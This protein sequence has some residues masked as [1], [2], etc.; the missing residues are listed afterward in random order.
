MNLQGEAVGDAF[1]Q[2][3]DSGVRRREDRGVLQQFGHE[4]REVG[5][6]RAADG[7]P[8]KTADLD[9]FVVLDLGDGGAHDVHQLHGLAPLPGGRGAGEDHQA[10][11]VPAHA[12]GQVVEAEQVGEFLGVLGPA[13]HGV[14]ESELLV[15]QDLAAAR[16]VDEDL[17]DAGAQFSL[18]DGGFDGGALQGVEGLADLAHLVLVVFEA[19]DLGLDV[20]LLARGEAAHDTGQ[21]YSGRFVGLQTQLP[22]IPDEGAADAHGQEEG[23]Q[24]RDQAECTG[25]DGLGDDADG[26]GVDAVLVAVVGLVV[27]GAELVEHIA[28]G[29]VPALGG[30]AAGT[31]GPGGDGGFLGHAQGSGG[32]VLPE[33][34]V[35]VAF[36]HGQQRQ[37]DVVHQGA[38]GHEVGD[39]PLFG[40]RDPADDQGGAEEGVLA[41]EQFAGAGEVDQRAVLLVQFGVVDHVQVGEEDVAGVDQPVV[42][43]EGLGA[44]DGA[45]LNAAAQRLDAVEG[46]QDGGQ[47]LVGVRSHRVAH[48]GVPGVLADA[49][50]GLV[51]GVPA[52]PERGEAVGRAG[53]GE[54]DEGLA[55]FLLEDSD[56]VLDGVADLLHHGR[57]VEEVAGLTSR[58]HRGE[59]PDRGQG[60][61]RHEKERHDLPADGFP[62]KAHGLPQLGPP[63][64]RGTHVRQQTARAYYRPT[65]NSKAGPEPEVPR[66]PRVMASCP[67]IAGVVC[68]K[69][70]VA[71]GSNPPTAPGWLA[72]NFRFPGIFV[73]SCSSSLWE[74]GAESAT[75][76]AS[77]TWAA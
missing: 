9:A 68:L 47:P 30:D 3:L 51:G 57:H 43:V 40:V 22:Q 53:V 10:F 6:G 23:E 19:R 8:R 72:E 38:L 21:P 13:L 70:V 62:A 5:D 48:V 17:G 20:D 65:G 25:D 54:V 49:A 50:D 24:Q 1:A 76:A 12:G 37:V 44:V 41:G 45:V 58:E 56:G 42:E 36:R 69:P 31:S 73:R 15:E 27:E 77:R 71:A 28:G 59:G 16:E 4:V 34:L 74:T 52:A 75:G 46:V 32:G 60:H 39:V 63:A 14:E 35:A 67:A 33:G 18:L 11:G 7:E 2:D 61:Q 66:Q 26:H 55:A 29:A 64:T